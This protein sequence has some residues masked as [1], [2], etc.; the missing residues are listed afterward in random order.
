MMYNRAYIEITN[1][2]NLQCSFCPQKAQQKPQLF[3]QPDAFERILQQVKPLVK[4][5]YLHVMGEPLTH[6]AL[7]EILEL[8]E[9]YEVT[10]NLTTNGRLLQHKK[11]V[12]L[13]A[14]A[15]RTINISL[16]SFEGDSEG[17]EHYVEQVLAFVQAG[18]QEPDCHTTFK[19]RVWN[20]DANPLILRKLEQHFSLEEGSLQQQVTGKEGIRLT[21]RVFLSQAEQ[22]QWPGLQEPI[23]EGEAFCLGM[24]RQFAILADG[25]V[26]PCCLDGEGIVTLGN[27]FK[28]ALQDILNSPRANAIRQGFRQG[29]AVEELCKRCQYRLRFQK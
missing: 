24:S 8:C 11:E 4:E 13:H 19:L 15:L 20:L 21:R 28:E 25:S 26:V 27:V 3:L 22:F 14:K 17:L 7:A 23:Y 5:V 2:C 9:R 12:L 16:H 6:P 18:L 29:K 10:A 1:V